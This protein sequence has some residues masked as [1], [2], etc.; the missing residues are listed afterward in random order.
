MFPCTSV[1]AALSLRFISM[2][3][4]NK[5]DNN[6]KY[7][8]SII[9]DQIIDASGFIF[10]LWAATSVFSRQPLV[11]KPLEPNCRTNTL[12][13]QLLS[14]DVF[15]WRCSDPRR[16]GA[17][18]RWEHIPGLPSRLHLPYYGVSGHPLEPWQLVRTER[19]TRFHLFFNLFMMQYSSYQL[20]VSPAF[21]CRRI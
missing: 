14:R 9:K 6:D 12:W 4:W 20:N 17:P 1:C 3:F 21:F 2:C 16:G 15:R 7:N 19:D 8:E 18:Q 13:L 5:I 11:S 10:A